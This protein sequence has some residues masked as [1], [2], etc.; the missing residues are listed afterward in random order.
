M[1]ER[2]STGID[3]LDAL[4]SGGIPR[5]ANILVKGPP[6]S[7]KTLLC[8]QIL[9]SNAKK[10]V[11]GLY[12]SFNQSIDGIK[13]QAAQFKWVFDDLPVE[14]LY[15]DTSKDTDIEADVLDTAKRANAEI[16]V[17]DSL[18]SFLSRPPLT[19]SEYQ[20]DPVFEAMKKFPGI[21]I[22]DDALWRAMT[23]RLLRRI[24]QSNATV[25]LVYEDITLD[26]IR[27]V[28]E[29]LADG[30]IRLARIESLGKRTLT[31]EKMRYTKHDLLPRNMTLKEKGVAIEK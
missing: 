3:E 31:V 16:I 20:I 25:L 2:V 19:G 7:F 13:K 24:S 23:T 6:G 27:G 28:C 26:E 9:Y 21:R 8:L 14:F 5:T 18:T 22:S 1:V 30:T 29:Y 10:G 12:V 15:M 4:I 17:I 11:P